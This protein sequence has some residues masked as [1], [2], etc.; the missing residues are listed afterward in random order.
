MLA[1]NTGIHHNVILYST[2]GRRLSVL[3]KRLVFICSVIVDRAPR[4]SGFH[5]NAANSI[6]GLLVFSLGQSL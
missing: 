6:I 5:E 4:H 1:F 2:Y 3:T